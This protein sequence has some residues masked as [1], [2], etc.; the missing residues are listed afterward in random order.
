MIRGNLSDGYILLDQAKQN[1][2]YLV[3]K[4]QAVRLADLQREA[5]GQAVFVS[6]QRRNMNSGC[7]VHRCQIAFLN[8]CADNLG[9]VRI[10]RF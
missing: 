6:M 9:N 10:F 3:R 8:E 2:A 5:Y 1:G 7:F 4:M